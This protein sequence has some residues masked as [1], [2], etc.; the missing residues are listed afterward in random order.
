MS[1]KK[2]TFIS[3]LHLVCAR[4][5][6]RPELCCIH[7]MNGYAYASDS[8]V[9]VKQPLDLS[10]ILNADILDG[11]S[12]H[13]ESFR[14][15]RRM[16]TVIATEDGFECTSKDGSKV[17]F[18]YAKDVV[19]PDFEAVLKRDSSQSIAEIGVSV[20]LIGLLHKAMAGSYRLKMVFQGI[21]KA[22]VFKPLDPEY[23]E[24]I[25]LVMPMMIN[26]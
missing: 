8:A 16:R 15:I 9:L 3:D 14:A 10:P 26:E 4:Y 20:Q 1:K 17:F 25:A 18:E 7:F 13:A 21:D 22:I 6:L 24:E 5:E 11:V 12:I 23:E 2:N 19:A